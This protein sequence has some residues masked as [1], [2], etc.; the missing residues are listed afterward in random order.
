MT[1]AEGVKEGD[2]TTVEP[3]L[4]ARHNGTVPGTVPETVP[5]SVE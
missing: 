3:R 2:E 1:V 4:V 5:E